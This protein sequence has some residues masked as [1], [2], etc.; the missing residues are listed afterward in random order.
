MVAWLALGLAPDKEEDSGLGEQPGGM[1]E[2]EPSRREPR[3]S[4]VMP[5]PEWRRIRGFWVPTSADTYP[6]RT[7]SQSVTRATTAAMP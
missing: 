7:A 5:A 1:A 3:A 4:S 2:R 6:I